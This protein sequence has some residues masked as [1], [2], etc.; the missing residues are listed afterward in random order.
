VLFG[1]VNHQSNNFSEI[2][3]FLFENRH[4]QIISV[5]HAHNLIYGSINKKGFE[6]ETAF[7]KFIET[8]FPGTYYFRKDCSEKGLND[9]FKMCYE[10][11]AKPR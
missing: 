1:V 11:I 10:E 9:F 4:I 5:C 2:V 7:V 6:D 8:Q 3:S